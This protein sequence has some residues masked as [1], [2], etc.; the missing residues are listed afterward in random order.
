MTRR[1]SI[2]GILR[3]RDRRYRKPILITRGFEEDPAD[4]KDAP[5]AVP[6]QSGIDSS[7]CACPLINPAQLSNR[8]WSAIVLQVI[9]FSPQARNRTGSEVVA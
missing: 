8:D 4:P 1:Q 3:P 6:F 5:R 2:S 7:G 9:Y